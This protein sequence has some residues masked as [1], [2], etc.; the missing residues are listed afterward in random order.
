MTNTK[1]RKYVSPMVEQIEAHVEK[2][3]AGSNEGLTDYDVQ[4]SQTSK[5][6]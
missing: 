1:K 3:F 4:E 5:F 6:N 2:G